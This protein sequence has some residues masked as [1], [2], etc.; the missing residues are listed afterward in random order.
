MSWQVTLSHVNWTLVIR[1]PISNIPLS[2]SVRPSKHGVTHVWYM[3]AWLCMHD[4]TLS[5]EY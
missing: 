3:S 4:L 2:P 5:V 1:P